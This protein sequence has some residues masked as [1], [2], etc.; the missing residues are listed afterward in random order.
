MTPMETKDAAEDLAR[1][2]GYAL[3]WHFIFAALFTFGA[4]LVAAYRASGSL[5]SDDNPTELALEVLGGSLLA[6]AL[7]VALRTWMKYGLPMDDDDEDV[8]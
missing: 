3:A 4:S 7:N 8:E 6:V 5:S 1:R 2:R